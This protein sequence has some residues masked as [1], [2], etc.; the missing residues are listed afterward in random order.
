MSFVSISPCTCETHTIASKNDFAKWYRSKAPKRF[1]AKVSTCVR[2]VFVAA[3]HSWVA[4]WLWEPTRPWGEWK[5]SK[6]C[7]ITLTPRLLP[8]VIKLP[9]LAG[10]QTSG[11]CIRNFEKFLHFRSALFGLVSDKWPPPPSFPTAQV[12]FSTVSITQAQ[13]HIAVYSKLSPKLGKLP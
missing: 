6:L 3:E 8:E 10:N 4:M 9:I 1:W 2:A 13:T 5:K 7:Q 11:K 12:S